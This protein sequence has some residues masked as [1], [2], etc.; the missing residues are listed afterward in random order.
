MLANFNSL[1]STIIEA[2]IVM[3]Q[4]NQSAVL[5]V[6]EGFFGVLF[7]GGFFHLVWLFVVCGF[8]LVLF[9]VVF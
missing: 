2:K 4:L 6:F 5:V 8:V 9:C 3:S 1:N 7:G